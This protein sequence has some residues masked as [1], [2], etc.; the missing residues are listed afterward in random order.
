VAVNIRCEI[1]GDRSLERGEP[2]ALTGH[3]LEHRDDEQ[4][5]FVADATQQLAKLAIV[6]R[7]QHGEGMRSSGHAVPRR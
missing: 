3:P 6:V 1:P 2:A 5:P 7:R 4:A